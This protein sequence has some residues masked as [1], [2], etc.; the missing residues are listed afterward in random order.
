MPRFS[1][2]FTMDRRFGNGLMLAVFLFT[3]SYLSAQD[4]GSVASKPGDSAASTSIQAMFPATAMT[5]KL[6]TSAAAASSVTNI[7]IDGSTKVSN[8]QRLG[9]NLGGQ[10]YYDSGQ[11]LRN[12]AFRNPGFEGETFR[13]ILHCAS[14]TATSCTDTNIYAQW[15]ANFVKGASLQFI[16]GHALGVTGTVSASTAASYSGKVGVTI[17]FAKAAKTPATGDFVELQMSVPGNAQAGWWT[18]VSGGASFATDSTDLSPNSPGK[19]ALGVNASGSGQSAEVVS[20]FD[21]YGGRSFVQ[22]NGSYE[23]TFRAKGTG[24]NKQLTITVERLQASGTVIYFTRTILLTSAWQDYSFSFSAAEAGNSIGTAALKFDVSQ[25]SLLLDD[26]TLTAAS[27]S[28]NPTAFRNEVVSTLEALHPGIIRYEDSNGAGLGGSIDNAIAPPFARVRTA[29]S[30]QETERDDITIGLEEFLELCK[31]VGANPWYNVPVGVSPAE[32]ENLIEFLGGSASTPYGAK[33]A[34]LGQTAPWTSVFPKI[35]LELGNEVWNDAYFHGAAMQDP[36]AYGNHAATIFSAARSSSSYNSGIFNLIL[37]SWAAVPYWT[38]TEMA[39]SGSYDT[40][41]AAP[42]L[43]NSFNDS[44]SN[45]AIFGPMF[46]QPE[47]V[48]SVSTG[49]MHQQAVAASASGVSNVKPAALAVYEVQLSAVTGIASQASVNAVVPSLGA[50]L[51]VVEHMLLM[52]RDLGVTVQNVFALPEYTNLFT[53]TASSASATTPLFGAVVDMGGQTNLRRPLFLAE[54]LANSA[55]LPYLLTT[56]VSGAN[57]TWNQALSTNDNIQLTGAH[58]IQVFAFSD[59][60]NKRSI[61]AFN[62]SRTQSLPVEATGAGAPSEVPVSI[63]LLT[64]TN[65]TDTNEASAKVAVQTE[66]V[67]GF[68][69]GTVAYLPPYSMFVLQWNVD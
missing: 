15:P 5:G 58:E 22:L 7:V 17:S 32:M 63:S 48:D 9:I 28:E 6:A 62:L 13:T 54:Q 34:A 14:A 46:A 1:A 50:G 2:I 19:Q 60:G 18:S 8:A 16:Y 11:I 4:S 10:T 66:T 36:I 49:T 59:G 20:Y 67:S 56:T 45:E 47:S 12:L 39:N 21:S 43:F 3:C 40:V 38:S 42:Y 31:T 64:S 52:M 29:Y 68:P 55:I 24:G 53:N 44:S 26:V 33:R 61:I 37:G 65:L 51:T 35:Y 69:A 41:D 57:P 30:E 23:I 27:N 25:G